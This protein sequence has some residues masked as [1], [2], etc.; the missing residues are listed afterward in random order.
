M[1]NAP[2]A[3]QG[4]IMSPNS[5]SP[6]SLSSIK[7]MNETGKYLPVFLDERLWASLLLIALSGVHYN[8]Y[9]WSWSWRHQDE[10]DNFYGHICLV[11]AVIL[12][13]MGL[14]IGGLGLST[15]L[16]EYSMN[17]LTTPN[18]VSHFSKQF[19]SYY[20][21]PQLILFCLS[22]AFCIAA[23]T[24]NIWISLRL[25]W[26]SEAI[27][28]LFIKSILFFFTIILMG[29]A[30]YRQFN[31]RSSIIQPNYVTEIVT[32]VTV[33]HFFTQPRL[34]WILLAVPLHIFAGVE[35]ICWIYGRDTLFNSLSYGF[36]SVLTFLTALPLI[37][38][39]FS[40]QYRTYTS[41]V[42]QPCI[43]NINQ[44]YLTSVNN[45]ISM[46]IL[47]CVLIIA[48]FTFV[49]MSAAI[50]YNLAH[51]EDSSEISAFV[52]WFLCYIPFIYPMGMLSAMYALGEQIDAIVFSRIEVCG[53]NEDGY[54]TISHL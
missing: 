36:V 41:T 42:N 19:I 45:K 34:W 46:N 10:S 23:W 44:H 33:G 9:G 32:S 51:I 5:T 2:F 48:S 26:P 4:A 8:M 54:H 29:I 30:S 47:Q 49:M 14:I 28:G 16:R 25:F 12:G 1:N 37:Y 7:P 22:T 52:A 39:S 38:F 13:V 3:G 53:A 27:I 18:N 40:K 17:Y 21:I 50:T 35:V 20:N 6:P 24:V 31:S 43:I 11:L 15:F